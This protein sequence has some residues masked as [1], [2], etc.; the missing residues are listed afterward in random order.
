MRISTALKARDRMV[1]SLRDAYSA[2]RIYK[3]THATLR[4]SISKIYDACPNAPAYASEFAR[5]YESAL[6]AELYQRY[7]VFGGMIDGVF[8]S[9]HRDRADYYE[10]HGF[11]PSVYTDDGL[12][13]ARGHYWRDDTTKP[14]FISAGD[15]K[16]NPINA[17]TNA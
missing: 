13:M 7:L 9:T 2:A 8:Y 16:T 11:A 12:V 17:A 10:R 4:E 15:W 6:T 1:A 5:G 14:F 3:P